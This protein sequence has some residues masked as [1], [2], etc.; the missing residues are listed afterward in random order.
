MFTF[1]FVTMLTMTFYLNYGRN[2]E[3]T[4]EMS[5]GTPY[6]LSLGISK[7]VMSLVWLAG[8]LSG[9]IMQPIVGT[10]SDR[11]TSSLGRRRPFMIGGSIAVFFSFI[12]I[13]WTREI[14][15]LLFGVKEGR[16]VVILAVLSFYLLDFAINSVQASCR[17][18]IVDA[19]PLSK[20]ESGN[21]WAGRMIGFGNVFGYFMGFVD[22]VSI[23]PFLGNTQLKVLCMLASL[24]LFLTVG[25]TSFCVKEKRITKADLGNNISNSPFQTL[26]TIIKSLRTLPAPIQRI[27]NTQFYAW[28]G[29]FPFLF[30]ST[31]WVSELYLS[32]PFQKTEG[33]VAGASIRAGSF[34]LFLFALV[35]LTTSCVL[36]LFIQ[37]SGEHLPEVTECNPLGLDL[38]RCY[39]FSHIIF[40]M[41]MIFTLAVTSVSEATVIIA[42]CGF[43][44]AV[45]LW[46][47]FSL[48][49]EYL[50]NSQRN[51][52]DLNGELH[53]DTEY[54]QLHETQETIDEE[55]DR[56][57]ADIEDTPTQVN[58]G[59]S[60]GLI[61][62]IHNM[63]I[64][65]PQ[66]VIT[67]ISSIV[68]YLFESYQTQPEVGHI[69]PGHN[70]NAIGWILRIGGV[71]AF[72]AAVLSVKIKQYY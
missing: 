58:A 16:L 9:L 13:G 66:F 38:P 72:V 45:T 62:G 71:T 19:L 25:I 55:N 28:I 3:G 65:F 52:T 15:Q 17:A 26:F 22:L 68:F 60:A 24:A 6:L 33:D 14:T 49:G 53:S 21:A 54:H 67:F 44:W 57:P 4:V 37:P 5:Y 34:A 12:M 39:T 8:P 48:I 41:S 30:Y 59:D 29:W 1:S 36:P 31:T 47:P 46:A 35:S 27:C 2:F 51:L 64:V 18:L 32:D 63:Y 10:Y 61:L 23:F 56:E 7:S 50:A 69:E 20:Q 70:P 42:I 40:A 43:S 11:C